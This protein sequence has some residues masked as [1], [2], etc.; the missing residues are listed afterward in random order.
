[1]GRLL[2][3]PTNLSM[4]FVKLLIVCQ[5]KKDRL[6]GRACQLQCSGFCPSRYYLIQKAQAQ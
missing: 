3:Q 1:M 2:P 5:T 4:T 6:D